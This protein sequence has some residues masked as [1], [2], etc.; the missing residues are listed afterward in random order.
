MWLVSIIW[1]GISHVTDCLELASDVPAEFSEVGV[2]HSVKHLLVGHSAE[3][4]T[5]RRRTLFGDSCRTPT[6]SGISYS[7]SY[8]ETERER[9]FIFP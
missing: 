5:D 2:Q 7:P 4:F 1:M 8:R 9:E 6:E 3:R